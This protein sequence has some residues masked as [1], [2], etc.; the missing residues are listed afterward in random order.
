MTYEVHVFTGDKSG[1]GTDANVFLIIY[2]QHDDSGKEFN[3]V[4]DIIIVLFSR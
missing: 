3:G 4:K 2:G 1:A